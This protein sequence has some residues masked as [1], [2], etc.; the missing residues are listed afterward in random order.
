MPDIFV[1][2]KQKKDPA[3]AGQEEQKQ[4]QEAQPFRVDKHHLHLLTAYH[5]NP[6]T[7]IFADKLD[8]EKLLLFLRRHFVTNVPWI[9]EAVGIGLVPVLVTIASMF[10]LVSI[11]FLPSNYIMMILLFY[12]FI[13][14]GFIFVNYL[15]WFYNISL[16]TNERIIDIDFSSIVF[17]NVAATKLAQ[18]EDVSY[19]QIGVVRSIFDY[20]DVLVQTAAAQDVFDF[21]A[22]PHPERVVKIIN[23]LMG[24]QNNA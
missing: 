8:N 7:I 14:A 2:D 5:E 13:L 3:R 9:L 17:E 18:I 4:K 24:K 21:L 6:S 15:T 19:S 11:D 20:G 10:H 16:V 1:G 22:V 12:Y 23:D